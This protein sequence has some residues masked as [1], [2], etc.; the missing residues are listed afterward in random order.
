MYY[1][2]R[3]KRFVEGDTWEQMTPNHKLVR[4]D[5]SFAFYKEVRCECCG[6]DSIEEALECE[7]CG[8]PTL[9]TYCEFCMGDAKA[10]ARHFGEGNLDRLNLLQEACEQVWFEVREENNHGVQKTKSR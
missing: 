4:G 10:V 2:E 7:V 3:C 9:E 8:D 6:S 5:G 1:C